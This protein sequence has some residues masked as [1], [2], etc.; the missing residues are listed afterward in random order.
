MFIEWKK[1][2][3]IIIERN[4]QEISAKNKC[5]IPSSSH[6]HF[7]IIQT[8]FDMEECA[9]IT[10]CICLFIHQTWIECHNFEWS[11]MN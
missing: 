2:V 8:R 11:G 5:I 1:S 7:V 9:A 10:E 6:F 3:G 4:T